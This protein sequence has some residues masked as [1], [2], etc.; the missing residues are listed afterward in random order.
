MVVEQNVGKQ[1]ERREHREGE[2]DHRSLYAAEAEFAHI[3]VGS[4]RS[5]AAE[6]G[7]QSRKGRDACTRL[8]YK[9]CA[10]EGQQD[11]EP[12]DPIRSLFKDEDRHQ[13]G[14]KGR[15]LVQDVG[16]GNPHVVNCPKVTEDAHCADAA[17]Q[18]H[19]HQAR[20]GNIELFS[21]A[22]KDEGR[23][24]GSHNVPEKSLLHG[25]NIPRQ[26]DKD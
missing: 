23:E 9:S 12:L 26:T 6:D 8:G 5:K 19:I 2:D 18:E 25:R 20:A 24:E 10:G 22:H 3:G 4:S 11:T 15:E 13:D 16:V 21:R 14:K 7:D 17:A 1:D